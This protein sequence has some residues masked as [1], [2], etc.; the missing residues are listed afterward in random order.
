MS[1]IADKQQISQQMLN[2]Q[3][4]KSAMEYFRN[5]INKAI[6]ELE[7]ARK[8]INTAKTELGKAYTGQVAKQKG[9]NLENEIQKINSIKQELKNRVEE[10]NQKINS[11]SQDINAKNSELQR[12]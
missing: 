2:L 11:L 9:K 1:K 10:L 8:Y 4:D 5:Q 3:Q 6:S 7:N 12:L